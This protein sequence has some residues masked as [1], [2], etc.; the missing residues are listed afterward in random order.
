MKA[1]VY[2]EYGSADVLKC[3][4]IEKPVPKD[5]EVLIKVHAAS[6]NP[7]DWR[8]ME[9]NPLFLRLFL[10]LRKPRLGRP[11]VD[12]SGE[13][14]AVGR[15]VTRFKLG[16]AV[17]GA[18]SGAF[19]EY[20]CTAESKIAMKPDNLTF[21]QAASVNV[22]GLTA[23]QGLRDKGKIQPG[24]K[25]LVNGAA[26]GVGTFAVQIAKWFGAHVTGVCSSRNIE[27]VR[28]IGADEV[29]DY[30]QQDFTTSDQRYDLILDCVGNHSFS[31][32]RRVLNPDGRLVGVGAPHDVSM[33]AILA[34]LIKDQVLS[35]FG[36]Q[37]AVIFIAKA[38]Q[39]DL[40][41]LGELIAS[42]KLKPV[43]D[44]HYG[45]SEARDAVRHL[46]EGHARGKVIIQV[47]ADFADYA[48]QQAESRTVM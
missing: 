22:A 24:S 26:G 13:V 27:M 46:E 43:I 23:L 19:A 41:L 5:D 45:L 10:G 25:V 21:E 39:E 4:E 9:G 38:S 36:S 1:I 11:G 40:K 42:G 29:I 18:C 44:R 47:S 6:V 3:E 20:V 8:L 34:S 14:E 33:M 31:E 2:H 35:I 48:E 16:D 32:C 15:N 30:T 17:F 28:S 12:V 37:K 7:L